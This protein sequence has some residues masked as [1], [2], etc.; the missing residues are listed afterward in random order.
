MQLFIHCAYELHRNILAKIPYI[1]LSILKQ[2]GHNAM[3]KSITLHAKNCY[4]S[5]DTAKSIYIT[6]KIIPI[7]IILLK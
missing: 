6:V 3:A 1:T 7:E 2:N 5:D 4:R